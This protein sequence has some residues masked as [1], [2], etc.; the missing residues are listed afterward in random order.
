MPST[1]VKVEELPILK[2]PQNHSNISYK[3]YRT[4]LTTNQLE[5]IVELQSKLLSSDFEFTNKEKVWCSER[6]LVRYLKA[7]SW[8][9]DA[10]KKRLESTLLWRREYQPDEITPEEVEPEALT[11]K[12][13]VTGFN[14]DA[15][16]VI[17]LLPQREN[18][19]T[20]D[21]Q[22]RFAVYNIEKAL[23]IM[24][25]GVHSIVILVDYEHLSLANATP[26]ST[27]RKFLDIFQNH[28][29]EILHSALVVNPSWYVSVFLRMVT[30]FMDP[31]T[32]KKIQ[33]VY[34][35]SR[36]SQTPQDHIPSDQLI[37]EYGGEYHMPWNFEIY[38]NEFTKL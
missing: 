7:T 35:N 37:T 15:C 36:D 29:P 30:P 1:A 26:L 3:H 5:T 18:T 34:L 22:I 23:K 4:G 24:P 20:Y 25:D 27:S 16:P 9:V 38:W 17:Y 13:F 21:R 12:S 32:R 6:C 28:Y 33:L 11:G 19:K 31:I 8:D 10:A 14:K 2:L